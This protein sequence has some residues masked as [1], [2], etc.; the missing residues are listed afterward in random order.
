MGGWQH[1]FFQGL[2]NIGDITNSVEQL[3]QGVS[4]LM[5][6][7]YDFGENETPFSFNGKKVYV[8]KFNPSTV[9]TL[10]GSGYITIGNHIIEEVISVNLLGKIDNWESGVEWF[11]F[12]MIKRGGGQEVTFGISPSGYPIIKNYVI[13]GSIYVKGYLVYTRN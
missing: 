3:E 12:P 1:N 10:P 4:S 8:Y 9:L 7:H 11:Q 6:R 13:T 5:D 2:P